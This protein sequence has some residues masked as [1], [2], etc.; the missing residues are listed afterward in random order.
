MTSPDAQRANDWRQNWST[1]VVRDSQA[2][3]RLPRQPT[4]FYRG[5]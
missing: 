5:V 1:L 3:R 2:K 4:D